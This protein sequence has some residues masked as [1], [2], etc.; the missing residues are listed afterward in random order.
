MPLLLLTSKLMLGYFSSGR[1]LAQQIPYTEFLLKLEKLFPVT[2]I[3]FLHVGDVSS[4]HS[5]L[6]T[7]ILGKKDGAKGSLFIAIPSGIC[8]FQEPIQRK[9]F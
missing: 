7:I 4:F 8:L 6:T 2:D 9:K 1:I 3:F 5:I